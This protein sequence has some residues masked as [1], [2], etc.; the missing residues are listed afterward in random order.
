MSWKDDVWNLAN[1]LGLDYER[2]HYSP[3]HAWNA[4]VAELESLRGGDL[5]DCYI[6]L[7]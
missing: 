2:G 5:S 1:T 4:I 3:I 6:Q 7:D